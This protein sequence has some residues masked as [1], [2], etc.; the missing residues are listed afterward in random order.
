MIFTVQRSIFTH[1][2][3]SQTD[4]YT[5]KGFNEACAVIVKWNEHQSFCSSISEA[6]LDLKGKLRFLKFQNVLKSLRSQSTSQQLAA[7]K[8][9]RARQSLMIT[10]CKFLLSASGNPGPEFASCLVILYICSTGKAVDVMTTLHLK[11]ESWKGSQEALRLLHEDVWEGVSAVTSVGLILKWGAADSQ[12]LV[13][14]V[15]SLASL[16]LLILQN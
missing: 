10:A 9:H 14:L 13:K 6:L 5:I 3:R 16:E 4:I 8:L 11:M 2:G 15:I 1:K 12:N 7:L